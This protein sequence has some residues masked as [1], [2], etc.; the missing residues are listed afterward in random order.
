MYGFND[1]RNNKS[2]YSDAY[3]YA[4][5]L[6]GQY[7]SLTAPQENISNTRTWTKN[8][9]WINTPV[10]S[11]YGLYTSQT[12]ASLETV[13]SPGRYYGFRLTALQNNTV[14]TRISIDGV[15]ITELTK[16]QPVCQSGSYHSYGIIIDMGS[17]ASRTVRMVNR[18]ATGVNNYFDFCATWIDDDPNAR[19]YLVCIP[20]TFNYAYTGS[21]PWDAP[22]DTK[23]LSLVQAIRDA[24]NTVSKSGLPI[25]IHETSIY[26]GVVFSDQIHWT[27]NMAEAHAN[28]LIKYS[29]QNY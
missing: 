19:P 22:S 10:Y 23:R 15:L 25:S 27:S 16:V 24:V 17:V 14:T 12:E 21:A 1:I 28:N 29:I 4:Q 11:T 3:Y 6:V 26:N 13:M 5:M 8:G 7:L 2:L 18:S 20:P 9:T